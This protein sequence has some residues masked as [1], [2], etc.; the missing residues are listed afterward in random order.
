[1][2]KNSKKEEEFANKLKIKV[3]N[4]DTSDI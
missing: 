2:I 4:V 1:M 3:G